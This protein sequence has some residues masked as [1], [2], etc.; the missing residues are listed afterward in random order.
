MAGGH[1][2]GHV[3]RRVR[4]PHTYPA[5][6]PWPLTHLVLGSR[7]QRINI[8]ELDSE[9]GTVPLSTTRKPENSGKLNCL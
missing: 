9:L 6:E 5:H 7:W 2:Y 8:A 3:T 1:L 4:Q